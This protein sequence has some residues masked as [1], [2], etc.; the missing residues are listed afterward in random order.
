MGQITQI[1]IDSVLHDS[2]APRLVGRHAERTALNEVLARARAGRGGAAVI[3]GDA[4]VGKSRLC[5]EIKTAAVAAH[6]RV[7][8]GRCSPA[9]A[10][11]P[12]GP[13]IDALRFRLAKGEGA[14]AAD[15]LQ[16]ILAHVAPLFQDLANPDELVGRAADP[17][18]TPFD[19]IWGVL[20][21]LTSLGPVLFIVEDLHWS[22][23]TSRDLIHYIVRRIESLPMVML[24]TY[25]TDEVPAGH[26]LHRMATALARDSAVIRLHLE[27]L[28]HAEVAELLNEHLHTPPAPDL[29]AAVA[30]RT[31][32]NPLFIEEL[33]GVL[34][35]AFP[36]RSPHYTAADLAEV[37]PPVTIADMVQERLA[38]LSG[39]AR[40]ALLVAAVMG[41]TFS[42]DLLR[43][44]LEWAEE[45][46]LAAV[47]ELVAHRFLAEIGDPG[48]EFSFRH[49]LVQEV[50]YA[51]V[52]AR[53][54]RVWHRRVAAVLE[55]KRTAGALPHARLAHHYQLG[56]D[57]ARARSHLLLSGDE[58]ARLCAWP[59]AEARYEQAL[60][61][62]EQ[63][64]DRPTQAV[65]LDRLAEVAWWQNRVSAVEQ[66]AR[67]ALAI[68]R[69]LGERAR[70][71]AL[72]RRLANLDAHQR[73]DYV[74]ATTRMLEALALVEDDAGEAAVILNDLGRVQLARGH[75]TDAAASFERALTCTAARADCAEEALALVN[76][77]RIAIAGGQVAIGVQRLELARAL[78]DEEDMPIE[79]AAEVFHA[80]IRVLDGAREHAQ[81]QE[82]VDAGVRFAARHR[83]RGDE[84]IYKAYG[85]SIRRRAG[86]WETALPQCTASVTELRKVERAELRE[87]LR[88]LG[89]L[90]R[91]SGDLS[92]AHTAYDEAMSLGE[93]DARIGQAL[94]LMA[95]HRWDAAAA[96]LESALADASEHNALFAMRVLPILIEV[97]ANRADADKAR[98]AL[99]QLES[100]T[101]ASDYRAGA[102]ATSYGR[103]LVYAA[104]RDPESA[105]A[106][107]R[108]AWHAWRELELPY[109]A[110]RAALLLA[111]L[112]N[113]RHV[114]EDAARTFEALHARLDLAQALSLLRQLGV[115]PR[116]R[117]AAPQLPAPLD[118][119]TSRE[120][121]VLV[122]LA[123]GRTN[124]QIAKVL[125]MSPKT[126]GNHVANIFAKLGCATRTEAAHLS[127]PLL[128]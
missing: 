65:I 120:A 92:A 39:D 67:E 109:E 41:R 6:M 54:R 126:V 87:A 28:N 75:A 63:E 66:Y 118:R 61:M 102:A 57:S 45:R 85:A 81:A 103:A 117:R 34:A 96:I 60:S 71:A 40:E 17:T 27:P 46:L 15:V 91:V 69:S 58:A 19:R 76:L 49:S 47:E 113:D 50:M 101:A 116:A 110:A 119:L 79:R 104:T 7:I 24:L 78:V 88:I 48:E 18:A 74:R 62:A 70:A 112:T 8:E 122:E 108:A 5:R 10:T 128:R 21:R 56:G 16:P 12:F 105:A 31:E 37:H 125:A 13:F 121:E 51:S 97:H 52:I 59:D 82:W 4:G 25:R 86:D 93:G 83:L 38:P 100:L 107:A 23:P 64:E 20:R 9:E 43:D 123:Q 84:A 44:V 90:C 36:E 98:A 80:G 35:R 42:F 2:A 99:D 30:Q 94:V 127:R 95:E 114:A 3:G 111:R 77:G 14:A 26:P 1:R 55:H 124:K 11:I 68:S 32:G 22:D 106:A 115:R 73:G 72:L 29:V 53:R 33:L 89:D